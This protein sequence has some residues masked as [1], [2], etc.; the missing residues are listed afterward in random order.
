[1]LKRAI[2]VLHI[3]NADAAE[4]FYRAQLGFRLEFQVPASDTKRDP[5]YLGVSRQGA[6]LYLSWHAGDGVA[7]GVVYILSD[8]VDALHA[9]FVA[10]MS[11]STS[12]RRARP[13]ACASYM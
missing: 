6:L 7:G 2:P 11:A 10:K 9:E 3:T 4:A 5:C 13:G 1:L 8:D 12:P